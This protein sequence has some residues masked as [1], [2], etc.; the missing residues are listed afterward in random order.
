MRILL[1]NN[2][3]AEFKNQGVNRLTDGLWRLEPE[4]QDKAMLGKNENVKKDPVGGIDMDPTMINL[5]IKRNGKGIP[6]PVPVFPAGNIR[7]D[8]LLPVIIN[9]QPVSNLQLL[10]GMASDSQSP[11]DVSYDTRDDRQPLARV[12]EEIGI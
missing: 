2:I 3:L 6:M 7:I 10:L 11:K 8:G 12:E 4:G 5:E 1:P 9:I